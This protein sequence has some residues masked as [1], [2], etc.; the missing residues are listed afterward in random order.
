MVSVTRSFYGKTFCLMVT[1]DMKF[2]RND[3]TVYTASRLKRIDNRRAVLEKDDRPISF[4][5]ES[6]VLA[7]G[8]EP[9]DQLFEDLSAAGI[10]S[11][12]IGDCAAPRRILEAVHEGFQV[13]CTL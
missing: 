12:K 4:A 8:A 11:L 9:V 2:A 3:V 10:A 7:V 5:V 6:V 13:G 1:T